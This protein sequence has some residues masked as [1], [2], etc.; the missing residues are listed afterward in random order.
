MK[1]F[2]DSNLRITRLHDDLLKVD[3]KSKK[4]KIIEDLKKETESYVEKYVK[5]NLKEEREKIGKTFRYTFSAIVILAFMYLNYF[6]VDFIKDLYEVDKANISNE[7]YTRIIDQKVIMVL[8]SGVLIETA[9]A[10]GLL[11]KSIFN[12]KPQ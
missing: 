3:D 8:I 7:N 2:I 11:A 6:I 5:E 9:I 1:R 4:E 12:I 10:F